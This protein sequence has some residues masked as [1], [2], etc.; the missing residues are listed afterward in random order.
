M[1]D[2]HEK[3]GKLPFIP[4]RVIVPPNFRYCGPFNPLSK[5]IRPC[6]LIHQ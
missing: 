1:I 5:Q 3:I 6:I 4:K 2:I